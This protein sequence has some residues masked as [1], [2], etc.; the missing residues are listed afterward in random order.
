MKNIIGSEVEGFWGATIPPSFGV[1]YGR[2]GDLAFI[3]WSDGKDH[4]IE[5]SKIKENFSGVGIYWV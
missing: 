1:V 3:R 2:K 4:K 5:V